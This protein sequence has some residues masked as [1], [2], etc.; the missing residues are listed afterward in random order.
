MR[1]V[2]RIAVSQ[3]ALPVGIRV[4]RLSGKY[5]ACPGLLCRNLIGPGILRKQSAA[6]GGL[7]CTQIQVSK[8]Q[9]NLLKTRTSL[10][11]ILQLLC[12]F[13]KLIRPFVT[14]PQIVCCRQIVWLSGN[15]LLKPS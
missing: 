5:Q 4:E 3:R 10:V 8:N 2:S 15:N 11:D 14:E 1:L 13:P 7:V 6:L 9:A 12:S